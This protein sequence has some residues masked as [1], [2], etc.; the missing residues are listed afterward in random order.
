MSNAALFG[1]HMCDFIYSM[2]YLLQMASDIIVNQRLLQ[3]GCYTVVYRYSRVQ[4]ACLPSN[5]WI[6]KTDGC[7]LLLL[8]LSNRDVCRQLVL[9]SHW[10]LVPT[11]NVTAW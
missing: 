6:F 4:P 3:H 9:T 1:L 11:C 7:F 5:C 2:V 8:T 10:F